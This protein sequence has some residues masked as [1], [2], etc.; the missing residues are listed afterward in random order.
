MGGPVLQPFKGHPH[1][2]SAVAVRCLFCLTSFLPCLARYPQPSRTLA[3][4]VESFKEGGPRRVGKLRPPS[5]AFPFPKAFLGSPRHLE[6]PSPLDP[7]PKL[8]CPKLSPLLRG[9]GLW[10]KPPV[11]LGCLRRQPLRLHVALWYIHRLQN[12]DMVASLRPIRFV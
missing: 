3:E 6:Y 8:S 2:S 12:C 1:I 11:D 7:L 4:V 5:T 9:A 10:Q